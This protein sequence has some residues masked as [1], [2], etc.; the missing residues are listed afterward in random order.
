[1]SV[2][3]T[4]CEANKILS[5]RLSLLLILASI[6]LGRVSMN[7]GS[8]RSNDENALIRLRFRGKRPFTLNSHWEIFQANQSN[9]N[10]GK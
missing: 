3:E 8:L 1:M 6:T 10:F 4:P 7:V 2:K 5:H 9:A